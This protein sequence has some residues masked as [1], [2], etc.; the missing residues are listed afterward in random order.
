MKARTVYLIVTFLAVSLTV[1]GQEAV[2]EK[3]TTQQNEIRESFASATTT[4][5]RNFFLEKDSKTEEMIVD[6]P[7][8][9]SKFDLKIFSTVLNGKLTIEIYDPKGTKLG[10][11]TVGLQSNSEKKTTGRITKYFKQPVSGAWKIKIIPEQATGEIWSE[12]MIYE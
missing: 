10:N 12:V 7:P 1:K 11:Y 2:K 6:I 3:L 5:D 4:L 8:K 9:S